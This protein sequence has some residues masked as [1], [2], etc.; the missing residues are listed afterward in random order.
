MNNIYVAGNQAAMEST[1]DEHTQVLAYKELWM[2]MYIV[3]ITC[4]CMQFR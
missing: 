2:Q 3:Y 4:I 1:A